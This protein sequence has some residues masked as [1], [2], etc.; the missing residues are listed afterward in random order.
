MLVKIVYTCMYDTSF[1]IAHFFLKPNEFLLK[2][3]SFSHFHILFLNFLTKTTF[4]WNLVSFCQQIIQIGP[5]VA[6]ELL[7]LLYKRQKNCLKKCM[8]H[9][10]QTDVRY[11][12]FYPLWTRLSVV[13]QQ[14]TKLICNTVY[15]LSYP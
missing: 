5:E 8:F 3:I 9:R 6:C 15:N 11:G 4:E 13:V 2:S 7:T 14:A 1:N 10:R 12:L